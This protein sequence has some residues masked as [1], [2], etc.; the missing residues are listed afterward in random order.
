MYCINGFT[1]LLSRCKMLPSGAK[2]LFSIAQSYEMGQ[3]VEK[4]YDYSRSLSCK[5]AIS[6]DMGF[7]F[8]KPCS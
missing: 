6:P 5:P 1:R 4:K 7:T 3:N 8:N 2:N